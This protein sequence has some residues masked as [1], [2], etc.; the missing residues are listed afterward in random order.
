MSSTASGE[1]AWVVC[2]ASRFGAISMNAEGGGRVLA[3][4]EEQRRIRAVEIER[5]LDLQLKILD[6]RHV[7]P[8]G[9]R[10]AGEQQRTKTVVSPCVV[11]PTKDD[12]P[13]SSPLAGARNQRAVRVD[14]L[15][16]Q[17]HLS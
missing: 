2:A 14:K 17:R 8:A 1:S 13:Q 4:V 6:R 15:Y 3:R 5:M 11:A 16:L 7:R 10:H 9:V 12:E